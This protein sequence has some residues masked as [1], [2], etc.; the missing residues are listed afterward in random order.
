MNFKEKLIDLLGSFGGIV[1]FTLMLI[2]FVFPVAMINISFDLPFW[3]NFIMTA[4]LLV[5]PST[6]YIF[7][8]IGL[9]GAIIGP[10]DVIA[11]IYYICFGIVCF[12]PILFII[13]GIFSKD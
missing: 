1:Y 6:F 8:I 12:R 7:W 9:I 13:L 11:V 4:I 5:I 3:T 10:Q 2:F